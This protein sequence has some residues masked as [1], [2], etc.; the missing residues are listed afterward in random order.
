MRRLAIATV[1]ML[2]GASGA[3]AAACPV[4]A[5][6]PIYA[7]D[8]NS[9]SV[10][11][12]FFEATFG[13]AATCTLDVTARLLTPEPDVFALYSAT[14]KTNSLEDD[15][16]SITV[17]R[18]GGTFAGTGTAD[19]VNANGDVEYSDFIAKSSDGKLKST[20]TIKVLTDVSN[21][22]SSYTFDSLD[23]DEF[24]RTTRTQVNTSLNQINIASLGL[25][26][27]LD[28]MNSLLTGGNRPVEGD[29]EVGTFGAIGSY[30]FGAHGRFNLAEGFSVLGGVSIFDF[31]STNATARGFGGA[32][33]VRYLDPN[34]GQGRLLIEG[35]LDAN[36]LSAVSFT[37]TYNYSQGGTAKTA[38]ATGTGTGSTAGIYGKAGMLWAVDESNEVL[39][40][41]TLKQSML[42]IA[43][44]AET[45]S[46]ANN[47]FPANLAGSQT[48]FTTARAGA[49]WTA[50]LTADV[51]LTASVGLGATFAKGGTTAVVFG[52][53]SATGAAQSTVFAD[54][55]VRLGWKPSPNF[56]VDGFLRGTTGTGIGTHLQAGAGARLTF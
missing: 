22:G 8:D 36:S 28:G 6:F 9:A 52:G 5:G 7:P 53:G 11:I 48:M 50:H 14:Y 55:G 27:H 17:D 31:A 12:D 25:V 26:T 45:F 2:A 51:D 38:T 54:Y 19:N 21:G 41:A 35:G 43:T 47:P 46:A 29:N 4:S 39:V 33:A 13:N 1:F 40:S 49:D 3:Y 42:G 32:I 34:P 20:V 15:T 56:G 30:D 18:N 24:A 44:Y 16:V 23:F 37:R 10:A